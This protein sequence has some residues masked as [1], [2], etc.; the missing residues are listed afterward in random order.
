MPRKP[1]EEVIN[2]TEVEEKTETSPVVISKELEGVIKGI[3][4]K[5][6]KGAIMRLGDQPKEFPHISTGILPLDIAT[7]IGGFPKGRIIEIYGPEAAGKTL[8]ALH[9]IA[10][11]QRIGKVCA[12]VDAE[13]AMNPDFAQRIGVKIEDLLF[14]QP[15]SGEQ[16]LDIAEDLIKSGEV[17]IVVIDSVSALVPQAELDGEMG[18][19]NIGLQARLMS[20]AMRK[21]A[22]KA[23]QSGTIVI[24]IN[25][26]REKVG[27]MFGNPETTTGGRSLPYYASMRLEVRRSEQIKDGKDVIGNRVKITVKKNKVGAPFKTATFDLMFASGASLSGS[28]LDMAIE[29]GLIEKAGAWYSYNGERIGQGRESAKQ[30]LEENRDTMMAIRDQIINKVFAQNGS[31]NYI[32]SPDEDDDA[33]AEELE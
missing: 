25:Q 23:N 11:A 3:E 27:V 31:A 17:A 22:G 4:K 20:K 30:W 5:F 7:G 8:I 32:P 13:N 10:E 28:V 1:K 33:D 16:A 26:I 21:L 14:S 29:Q 19:M 2:A 12:Y 9:A 18:D 24:F 15:E 6:G